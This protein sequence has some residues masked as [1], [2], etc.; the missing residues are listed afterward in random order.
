MIMMQ[1]KKVFPLCFATQKE[2]LE[3]TEIDSR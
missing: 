1:M 2:H 3:N